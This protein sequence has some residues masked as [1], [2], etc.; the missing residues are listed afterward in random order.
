[1]KKVFALIL[2]T[3]PV[4][5]F[6]S[7]SGDDN[8]TIINNGGGGSV[9][10]TSLVLKAAKA[11]NTDI[12][13]AKAV[14]VGRKLGGS[15]ASSKDVTRAEG[16]VAIVNSL[17]KASDDMKFIEV[18]YTFDVE[19]AVKDENGNEEDIDEASEEQKKEVKTVIE[20]INSSLRIVPNFIF[21]VGDNYL[22][23][24]NCRYEVP[25]YNQMEES[26]VKKMLT[27]IRD[28][29]NESHRSVHGGQ[30]FIRKSDG[31]LFIWEIKDG[32]PN[33]L[34][35]GYNPQSMLNGWLHAIGDHIYVREGGYEI[36]H[37][38]P[39]GRVLR[40]TDNGTS[41]SYED[42]IPAV[43]E[44]KYDVAHILPAGNN[45]G[46]V[47]REKVMDRGE[48]KLFPVPYIY[49]TSTNKLTRLV[50][51]E[52]DKNDE[53][54]H[55]SLI[56]I[57]GEFYAI[58]NHHQPDG[59]PED[60]N[61]I[62]FYSVNVSDATV[63]TRL[64]GT[65]MQ[66]GIGFDDDKFFAKGFATTEPTF[67]FIMSD[68]GQVPPKR[69]MYI[70]DPKASGDGVFVMH[71]LP[72][73]YPGSINEFINGIACGDVDNDGFYVCDIN[74]NAAV[75]VNLDWS[76][77]SQ[78]QSLE[79]KFTHFEAGNMSIKYE[80]TTSDGQKIALWVPVVG[81]NQGKVTVMTG[82]NGDNYD[83]DVVLNMDK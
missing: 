4:T 33:D 68:D 78:Y 31:A 2:I 42:I 59:H 29:F 53:N 80:A 44:N 55:W 60:P 74:K 14:A 81:E 65:P 38:H 18:K 10:N 39:N 54:T 56:T 25:D 32:A 30:Y 8:T 24:S 73:H 17:L 11:N 16:D 69:I 67:K 35:D 27:K 75:R 70:F 50:I 58:R 48:E 66:I 82:A 15:S 63:G 19:V 21:D 23:L 3:L 62:D 52:T 40:V 57:A 28:D 6:T 61:R 43:V 83:I 37:N 76:G 77:A 1:M 72:A 45:L 13:G 12:T 22:W 36:D 20:R 26:P 5:M 79:R 41:L 34:G 46:V 47:C 64:Y 71:E 7:C 51:P 9:S 49:N